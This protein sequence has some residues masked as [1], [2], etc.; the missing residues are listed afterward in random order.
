[1]HARAGQALSPFAPLLSGEFFHVFR[2]LFRGIYALTR[3]SREAKEFRKKVDVCL[4]VFFCH[5]WIQSSASWC[6][7]SKW[8]SLALVSQVTG[9]GDLLWLAGESGPLDFGATCCACERSGWRTDVSGSGAGGRATTGRNPL[10]RANACP[11]LPV[12]VPTVC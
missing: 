12:W 9:R 1:M 2:L 11:S 6:R 5:R 8:A 10:A 4:D 7:R 3:F